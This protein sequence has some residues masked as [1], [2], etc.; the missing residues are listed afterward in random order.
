MKVA[1]RWRYIYRAIDQFG[2]VIDALVSRQRDAKAARRFFERAI[3]T[4]RITP[5]EV[6]TDKAATYPIALDELLPTAWHRTD[7]DANNHI[8]A[9]HGHLLFV[10]RTCGVGHYELAVE[11]P[12]TRRCG[13]SH[14][15]SWPWRSDARPRGGLSTPRTKQMQHRRSSGRLRSRSST[16]GNGGP[17]RSAVRCRTPA[18]P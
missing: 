18:R 12:V 13:G 6:V 15:T 3:G 2:Q 7:Q 1:G 16:A 8:E 17:D 9:D 4:T 5:V 14:S 10:R 11:E